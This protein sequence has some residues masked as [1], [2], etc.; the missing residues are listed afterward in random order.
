MQGMYREQ[1]LRKRGRRRE[2][3]PYVS[4]KDA[5]VPPNLPIP[6]CDCGFVAH[7]FQSRHLDTTHCFYTCSRFNVVIVFLSFFFICVSSL[8]IFCWNL[9]V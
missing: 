2:L 9:V 3:Y 1:L 7:V 6:N 4:S 8:L 5:P